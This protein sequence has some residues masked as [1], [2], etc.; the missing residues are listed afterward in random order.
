MHCAQKSRT[1]EKD[2]NRT[3]A[4]DL[5]ACGFKVMGFVGVNSIPGTRSNMR[6]YGNKRNQKTTYNPENWPK[7]ETICFFIQGNCRPWQKHN[8]KEKGIIEDK[9]KNTSVG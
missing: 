1:K 8:W 6:S 5:R 7:L 4:G 3:C 9:K 2:G